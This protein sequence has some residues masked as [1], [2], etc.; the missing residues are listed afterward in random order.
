MG[1]GIGAAAG[2]AAGL[3]SV[4]GSRGPDA[5]LRRGTTVEMMLD[6]DLSFRLGEL[7]R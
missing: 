3:A 6:R 5:V 1:V 2:A 7:L 4:F